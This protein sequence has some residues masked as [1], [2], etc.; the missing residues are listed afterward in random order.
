VKT[1]KQGRAIVKGGTGAAARSMRTL[2]A[3][4]SWAVRHEILDQN[5]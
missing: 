5:L 4:T 1:K 3:M 2:S